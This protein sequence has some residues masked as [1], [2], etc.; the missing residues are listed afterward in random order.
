MIRVIIPSP[1]YTSM[2]Q[3]C[4][5]SIE[6][7]TKGTVAYEVLIVNTKTKEEDPDIAERIK[8]KY[9]NVKTFNLGFYHFATVN[10]KAVFE[11]YKD[12]DD[13]DMLCFCNSDIEFTSDCISEMFGL[14][15]QSRTIG[16]VGA[17]LYFPDNT[18]QHAGIGLEPKTINCYHIGYRKRD[19][20]MLINSNYG[21]VEGNTA[22]LMMVRCIVFRTLKGFDQ[23]YK[24]CFEDLDFNLR[25]KKVLG[26]NNYICYNATAYHNE[27]STR[28]RT[29]DML[30]V[31][32]IRA[33]MADFLYWKEKQKNENSSKL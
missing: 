25:V 13:E 23:D 31:W 12:I 20:E 14:A 18:I 2:L 16:T 32:K 28:G 4:I 22:A 3:D 19:A 7:Q 9:P 8:S 10:N 26:L 27:S 15:E 29:F 6:S 1:G 5:D 21:L 30:D 17:L 11:F 24:I 33:K